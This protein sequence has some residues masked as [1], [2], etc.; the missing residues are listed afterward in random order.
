MGDFNAKVGV[1]YEDSYGAVGRHGYGKRNNRGDRLVDFCVK[2]DHVITNTQFKQKK[3][4]RIWTWQSPNGR[5]HNQ[6]DYIIVSKTLR[7][8][9][10]NS[11]AYPSADIGP[12]ADVKF[13]TET[14]K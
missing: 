12:N 11:R 9:V 7:S 3:V 4:N 14:Q 6:M 5:D 1:Q 13:Q 2:N 10:R 8:S